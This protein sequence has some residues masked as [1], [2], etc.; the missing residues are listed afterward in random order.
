MK[1]TNK[2]KKKES[3]RAKFKSLHQAIVDDTKS[4]VA[5]SSF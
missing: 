3:E 4:L 2:Q 5:Y 1:I